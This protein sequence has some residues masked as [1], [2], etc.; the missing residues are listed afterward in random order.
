MKMLVEESPHSG[1]DPAVVYTGSKETNLIMLDAYTGRVE[2]WFGKDGALNNPDA[3]C[4]ASQSSDTCR[5]KILTFGQTIYTVSIHDG[6]DRHH[7]ATL[8]FSEWTPNTYDKDLSHQYRTTFDD[9]YIYTSHDGGLLGLDHRENTDEPGRLFKH[10]LSSP[11]ARIFD[12]ARPAGEEKDDEK[13][14]VLPQP[15]PPSDKFSQGLREESIFL[16]HTEDGSWYAMSGKSYPLAVQGIRQAQCAQ[17]GW[18]Q[19]Q[20]EWDIMDNKYLSKLLVGLHPIESKVATHPL[21]ALP[22]PQIE[23]NM[24]KDMEFS[25][26]VALQGEPTFTQWIWQ[27]PQHLITYLAE[28][29]GIL[30]N[31]LVYVVLLALLLSNHA[32]MRSWFDQF[33]GYDVISEIEPS[34]QIT[35]KEIPHKADELPEIPE[36]NVIVIPSVDGTAEA[37][38]PSVTIEASSKTNAVALPKQSEPASLEVPSAEKNGLSPEKEKGKKAHR[39][40]RGGVKHKKG[41]RAQSQSVSD[42]GNPPPGPPTVEDA[43]RYAQ[44]MGQQKTE[45]EPDIRTMPSDPQEVSGPI[46]RIGALEVNTERLIGT[47]SNGTMVFEG[48]FDGREVAVKRMLIQFFD[49]ASQETKLLRESDDHPN[50]I[51]YFAQQQAAGFLY[52]ALELCPASL[53]DVIDKPQNHRVLAQAG[54]KDL[55][56]VLYQITKGLSHLHKLRIVH[57]DLKPQNILVSLDKE[58]R[59]RLLVSD[60]GLCKKLEGEQ[61]SFRATT[62]H[63][64]GTSGWRAPELLLDDDAKDGHQ[65]IPDAST[66]GNS[67]S[68]VLNADLLPNRRATR[69]IDIF[70]LGLVFFYVLTQGRHPFDCGSRFMREVNIRKGEFDLKPLEVLGDY[71]YEA[72]DLI[73]QMLRANPKERPSAQDI[74]AHPFFWSAKRRLEFLCNVSDYFEKEKRDPPTEALQELERHAPSICG[75]DFLKPLGKD[76]VES[77][78]KQRKYTGTRLLDLLRALRNKKNH[79]EDMT[80]TLKKHVGPLP[81]G[82]LNFWTRRF[83]S[84]LITCWNVVYEVR[85]E[86]TDRFKEYYIPAGRA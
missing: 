5:T 18:L 55:P 78:G 57:R 35:E 60:F 62:A 65:T 49:I 56:D 50:V 8:K 79:Y 53:A 2:S 72:T 20:S 33:R 80:D 31:P 84:L 12:V 74:M 83:P 85:W 47:G 36:D 6:Q 68:I 10:K 28:L 37:P 70:S 75:S 15:L 42:D 69:A 9:R 30:K 44:K 17:D 73:G 34:L 16:N 61:S 21:L 23:K 26:E 40:R 27:L 24:S 43:V 25:H 86:E 7:I 38:S 46:I 29:L 59:P 64:A 39:G 66:E 41:P 4:S 19:H 22:A 11:V 52:I 82:Y 67:G 58:G 76:F 51:R 32:K 1:E 63:A 45:L 77:L 3:K 81:E 71:A 13:L 54:E 14:I 48:K